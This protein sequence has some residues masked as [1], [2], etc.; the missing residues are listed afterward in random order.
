MAGAAGWYSGLVPR[1]PK[2][3]RRRVTRRGAAIVASGAGAVFLAY[4]AVPVVRQLATV[5]PAF[6]PGPPP[7]GSTTVTTPDGVKLHVET[8]GDPLAPLTVVFVHGFTACLDEFVLQRAALQDRARLVFYDQ[9]GHGRSELGDIARC[10]IDQTGEDLG[11]VI[12]A[13]A[14]A[15]PV[16]VVG[17]S[18]GGMSVMALARRRPELFGET[19]VGAF[20]LA[21]AAGDLVTTGAL[22]H[23]VAR[24]RKV[25]LLDPYLRSLQRISPVLERLR[26]P[27]SPS[28]RRFY[29]HYLFGTD[30]ADPAMV[31]LIMELL[32]R[33]PV[34]VSSAF[35]PTFLDHDEVTSLAALREVP[36]EILCGSADRL[37]PARHSRQ[38]AEEIGPTATLT[39]VPGAG[40]SVNATR[41]EVVDE[42]LLR[43]L[44]RAEAY[45]QERH[46]RVANA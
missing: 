23:A 7:H 38:M 24:L 37:T 3:P 21:T 4:R 9:R 22:G 29:E 11:T 6:D 43:L 10:T 46:A 25:H 41:S 20:L 36:V 35:W 28:A 45:H 42:A 34:T 44:D 8:D 30:D 39:V 31:S 19:I 1:L 27:G 16:V 5:R 14:P 18:M 17:H 40:H 2:A 13:M 32:E 12:D 33:T 26:E 15:G